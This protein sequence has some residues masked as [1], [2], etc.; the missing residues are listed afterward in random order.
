MGGKL[1]CL[2]CIRKQ[3]NR[4][5]LRNNNHDESA[6]DILLDLQNVGIITN[7]GGGIKF[8]ITNDKPSERMKDRRPRRLPAISRPPTNKSDKTDPY[9]NEEKDLMVEIRRIG[10][11]AEKGFMAKRSEERRQKVL[12]RRDSI[13]KNKIKKTEEKI[14]RNNGIAEKKLKNKEKKQKLLEKRKE[15]D[16]KKTPIIIKKETKTTGLPEV[17]V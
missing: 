17:S 13:L 2:N 5:T 11:L 10:A 14:K 4:S 15:M 6:A 8:N 9:D 12:A 3:K 7:R 1:S 16:A